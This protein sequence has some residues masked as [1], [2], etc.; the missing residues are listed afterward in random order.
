MEGMG[1]KK[2]RPRR[3][4][5][6]ELKAETV[7][8]CRGGD[9]SIGR[10]V[11]AERSARTAVRFQRDGVEVVLGQVPHAGVFG[12]VLTEQAIGVLVRAALPRVARVGEVHV[13]TGGSGHLL[14]TGE[15]RPALPRQGLAEHGGQAAWLLGQPRGN[16]GC[17]SAVDP[18]R[19]S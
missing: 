17:V 16:G 7:E 14:V 18:D 15:L 10:R 19:N 4:L 11:E 1:R 12:Q 2:P 3:S 5:T 13:R 8:P 6:P 9:R